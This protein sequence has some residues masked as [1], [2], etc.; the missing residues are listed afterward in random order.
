MIL[1]A[2]S[3]AMISYHRTER[4]RSSSLG[5]SYVEYSA[6]AGHD[7]DVV[8]HGSGIL[9]ARRVFRCDGCH[10]VESFACA[11]RIARGG[12]KQVPR[13]ARNDKRNFE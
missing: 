2:I 12:E 1:H 8:A 4:G 11:K 5:Y 9:W 10:R 13:S 3:N 7:V 6:L